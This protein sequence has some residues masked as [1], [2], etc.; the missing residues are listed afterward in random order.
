M[1]A[2]LRS[3]VTSRSSS[4][5]A[6][7]DAFESRRGGKSTKTANT[8]GSVKDD[9]LYEFGGDYHD[10]AFWETD[11]LEPP[12]EE[13]RFGKR[14]GGKPD[15]YSPKHPL[16]PS[17]SHYVV[18]AFAVRNIVKQLERAVF[19]KGEKLND[20][21]MRGM[22]V[23][24]LVK[25]AD[26]QMARAKTQ[27]ARLA[28]KRVN[29]DPIAP[30]IHPGYSH[31]VHIHLEDDPLKLELAHVGLTGRDVLNLM[32]HRAKWQRRIDQRYRTVMDVSWWRTGKPLKMVR[33]ELIAK[34]RAEAREAKK[35]QLEPP[36]SVFGTEE[37]QA[38]LMPVSNDKRDSVRVRMT[39]NKSGEAL[40]MHPE[41]M[42]NDY[43]E[44]LSHEITR[45]N[46]H[47]ASV[48]YH[49]ALGIDYDAAGNI[50]RKGSASR[51]CAFC[52]LM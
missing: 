2:S 35:N 5:G 44:L 22:N 11:F 9:S 32:K 42:E 14:A 6:K 31:V 49:V 46:V 34:E 26:E 28:I 47:L 37:E 48:K 19:N 10:T 52:P 40:L 27:A 51:I 50:I 18:M 13:R 45:L 1:S 39:E 8:F 25:L 38:A 15:R 17:L 36:E 4:R 12:P 23:E 20:S 33:R 24:D 21:C 30:E 41:E 43:L 29:P 7:E 3:F 16:W